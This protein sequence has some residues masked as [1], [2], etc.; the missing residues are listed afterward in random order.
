MIKRLL[1]T[2]LVICLNVAGASSATEAPVPP[3]TITMVPVD[4]QQWQQQLTAFAPDIVVVDMWA[5]WCA[6]CIERFPKMVD[7]HRRYKSRGVRFVSLNLDDR[8]DPGSLQAAQR[9]LEKM[10]AR[11]HHYRLD[12]N[13]LEAFQ[14]LN[15]IGIPAVII[16]GRDG[17]ERYRLTGDNPNRQFT[18]KDVEKALMQLLGES[19]SASVQPHQ[20]FNQYP[21]GR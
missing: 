18:D 16:Y 6:S 15:L 9:F 7:M 13:L 5:M 14:K 11:F 2:L 21:I 3:K 20:A 10:D 1:A 8:G 17:R 12:E 4:Y 19:A